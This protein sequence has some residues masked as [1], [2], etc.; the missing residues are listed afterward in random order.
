M[1]K[2]YTTTEIHTLNGL[3]MVRGELRLNSFDP[4]IELSG[5]GKGYESWRLHGRKLT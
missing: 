2:L 5:V 3:S 1:V 4:K